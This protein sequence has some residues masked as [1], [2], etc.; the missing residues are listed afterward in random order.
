M[1]P[2]V[3]IHKHKSYLLYS[4]KKD[5]IKHKIHT[6]RY[7]EILSVRCKSPQLDNLSDAHKSSFNKSYSGEMKLDIDV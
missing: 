3:N 1:P 5:R 6:Y 7:V 4:T 2:V